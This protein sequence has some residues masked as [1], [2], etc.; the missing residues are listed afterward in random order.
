[1]AYFL[2]EKSVFHYKVKL[3]K[4]ETPTR[5][6]RFFIIFLLLSTTY[7]VAQTSDRFT[8]I[9]VDANTK[10]NEFGTILS[11]D[12]AIYYS[13][14]TYKNAADF[15]EKG[16]SLYRGVLK[17]KGQISK[18]LKF[19]TEATHAV[20]SNDGQTVYYSKK[21]GNRKFQLYKARVD[22]TGR[23]R[24]S[25]KLPFDN[26]NY[27][28]KQP[29]LNQDNTKLFFVS[30]KPGGLGKNDIYYVNITNN[31]YD[32]GEPVHLGEQINSP[33]NEMYPFVGDKE[34]L[35][36]STDGRG[37]LGGLDIYESFYE[38]GNYTK[39]S[40][41]EAPINS[42]KDDFAYVLIPGTNKG[43]FS[44]NRI[45]GFGGV[46]IYY[47]KDKKPSLNKCNQSIEGVVRNKKNQKGIFEVTVEI[48]SSVDH[49]GTQLT[50]YKGEFVFDNVECSERYD[51]V[52]YKEG[53]NGFSEV[54]TVPDSGNKLTLYLDTD[55]P[56]EYTEEFNTTDELVVIDTET[57]KVVKLDTDVKNDNGEEGLSFA[58]KRE[59]DRIR[60]ERRNKERIEAEREAE[61][62]EKQKLEEKRLAEAEARRLA[63]DKEKNERIAEAKARAEKLRFE[64]ELAKKT[65]AERKEAIRIAEA[66]KRAKKEKEEE[67][68]RLLAAQ[69][70][71]KQLEEERIAKAEKERLE[72][73]E[74]E[75]IAQELAEQKR[76]EAEKQAALLAQQEAIERGRQER[77]KRAKALAEKLRKQQAEE[78]AAKERQEQEEAARVA[79]AEKER[80]EKIEK[81][82]IAQKLAEQKRIEAEKQAKIATQ[83]E[84]VNKEREERIKK[85][86]ATAEKLRQQQ[87]EEKALAEQQSQETTVQNPAK[88]EQNTSNPAI[89]QNKDSSDSNAV[90]QIQEPTEFEKQQAEIEKERQKRIAEAQATADR[91]RAE[92]EK[93]KKEI[94]QMVILDKK[95]KE[96]L[97]K[98]QANLRKLLIKQKKDK[99]SKY[100]SK[101][102]IAAIEKRNK[103]IKTEKE[104]AEKLLNEELAAVN[105]RV[106]KEEILQ[107]QSLKIQEIE[108]EIQS[109]AINNNPVNPENNFEENDSS[110]HLESKNETTEISDVE[111]TVENT[112]REIIDQNTFDKQKALTEGN[113]IEVPQ[114]EDNATETTTD[115][116]EPN[117]T[118][119]NSPQNNDTSDSNEGRCAR[120]INGIIQNSIDGTGL[121]GA[122]VDMYFDGQ[123]IESTTAND[124]GEFHFYNVDCN[125]IYTLISFKKDF[126]NIAKAEI[127]TESLPDELVLLLEPNPEE[128]VV[129][130]PEP[131]QEIT[132]VNKT[133]IKTKPIK[134]ETINKQKT[135]KT[136]VPDEVVEEEMANHAS[137][138]KI[139]VPKIK[140]GKILIN[141]I[142]FDLD[143]YYLTLPAR[144]ELDK[145]IVIMRQNPTMIIES[146]SHT[147][148]RGDFDYNLRL[149]EKRSQEVVGYL[150][151]NGADPDRISGR[152]YGETMPVNR[153]VDGVKCTDKEYLENRRTEFVILRY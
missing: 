111:N 153:C 34:K 35:F 77:I 31:G 102:K 147:D 52:C 81:E 132:Q 121:A 138:E 124:K 125:T 3:L 84:T 22:R 109:V 101:S 108:K 62:I 86:Q 97:Q 30:D 46:D 98:S 69:E 8:V 107:K 40:N 93:T 143:E 33:G 28:F 16:A 144:R 85:A 113:N 112:N 117:S 12:G 2:L 25:I 32:F 19:P 104:K 148:S 11:S 110:N 105:K 49:V 67:E 82:K 66:K 6:K 60:K 26:P 61:R 126:S 96:E 54:Q 64:Q 50:N 100:K 24:N 90:A 145:I 130:T 72:K 13:K 7:V 114:E 39:T 115:S 74:K 5:M 137:E 47:F 55:F 127:N 122:N 89:D 57:N 21:N 139:E 123:N 80:L 146:G 92:Q 94:E 56:E 10:N 95:R 140:E 88:N 68:A 17:P 42:D 44:S 75:R 41:L 91:I 48:F 23:W 45:D 128:E 119:D 149:S 18:G 103:L 70:R 4:K 27:T 15:N 38:N 141:P 14:S 87:A 73:I 142:Y 9:N 79:A 118:T 129:V 136:A 37:G 65:E 43:Y 152:G 36:F 76:I 71:Q 106:E 150:V 120:T 133:E 83:Q 58:E 134:K 20:F 78:K 63:A 29:A 59:R 99:K 135:E 116:A 53:W 131:P 51:I 1:M 151:A